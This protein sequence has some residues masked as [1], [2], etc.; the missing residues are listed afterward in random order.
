MLCTSVVDIRVNV[1]NVNSCYIY[2]VI[3]IMVWIFL[4]IFLVQVIAEKRILLNDLALVQSQIHELE[5]KMEDVVTK[6]SDLTAKYNNVVA[7]YN[8]LSTKYNEQSGKYTELS[9]KYTDMSAMVCSL[10]YRQYDFVLHW[11]ECTLKK[12]KL[13][14]CIFIVYLYCTIHCHRSYRLIHSLDQ[15]LKILFAKK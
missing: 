2:L 1:T 5:R 11:I 6:N 15:F 4:I 3:T 10:N 9:T 8:D 7:K 12:R 13:M 14:I